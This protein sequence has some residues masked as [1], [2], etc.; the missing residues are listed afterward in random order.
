MSQVWNHE[1]GRS[2]SNF[3]G[4]LIAVELTLVGVVD[5]SPACARALDQAANALRSQGHEVV[6]VTPPSPFEALR[7][8]SALLNSDGCKTFRL[9]YRTGEQED[10]GAAQM[11]KYMR[12]SRPVQYLCYLWIKY[13]RQDPIWAALLKG[14]YP[15]SAFQQWQL[16]SRREAY[17]A[18]WHKWWQEESKLDFVLTP[19]NATPA[20]PHRAMKDAV[21][22][23]GYTFLF[24]LVRS[25]ILLQVSP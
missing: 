9:P 5:P 11:S 1:D 8:A 16:V 2:I 24:N 7:I 10:A 22:S 3:I 19:P 20:L 12:L 4:S 23:C 18:K 25:C 17:K 21:S 13:I 15:K 6:D 14:F